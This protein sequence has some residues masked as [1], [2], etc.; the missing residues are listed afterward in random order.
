MRVAE[1]LSLD[2]VLRDGLHCVYQPFVD[3]DSGAVLAFEA[4]LRGPAGTAWQSP[5][6]LLDAARQAGRLADLERAS[7][8]ASLA[9][10]AAFTQGRPVTLFVN[11]EPSTLTQRPDV[12]LDALRDRAPHVQVV[13]EITERAL[14][15][16]LAAVLRGAEQLR[17]AGCAIALDDVG[18]HPESLAFIPLLR[19]EV[20]KLDLKLLRTVKDPLTVTVAGA[21]R[22]YAE[23][24]GA[25]VV[26]EGIET[27]EDL[28]RALVLGATLGQGWLWSRGERHFTPSTFRPERFAARPIGA[29]LRTTP[30]GLIGAGRHIRHA[31]KHLLVPVSK[32]LEL[33]AQQ[34][35]V[36]PVLFA[37]FEHAQFF[38]PSTTRRFTEL[39]AKLPF[40]AALGVQMPA[41]PAPGVRGA[42]LSPQDPLATEWT[43]VVLGAHTAA[44]LMARDL[45]DTGPDPDRQF[46]FVVTYDRTLVT[47]AAHAMIGRLTTP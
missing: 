42:S 7:L 27:P 2:E 45:G 22:A 19:P 6:A 39:A 26:A 17:A 10:A 29:T 1:T 36:P 31:P 23:Q 32:T 8:R 15:E 40:V 41:A 11:L 3:V 25:E 33:M 38:R 18:V 30:Y 46:E 4:L 24:A 9:D 47:A 20:V 12:V 14:A 28:T 37:A 5:M 21:V 34:A 35:T 43:V 16:D 44:A 13:V